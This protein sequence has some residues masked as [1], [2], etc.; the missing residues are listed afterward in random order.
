MIE[1]CWWKKGGGGCWDW[2]SRNIHNDTAAKE[3]SCRQDKR[4]VAPLFPALS[5]PLPQTSCRWGFTSLRKM[6][7]PGW[8][9]KGNLG[10]QPFSAFFPPKASPIHTSP[11]LSL[12]SIPTL[13]IALTSSLSPSA[14]FPFSLSLSLLSP[15]LPLF[16]LISLSPCLLSISPS[17]NPVWCV[18][19]RFILLS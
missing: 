17:Q 3:G 14:T 5:A 2:C 9:R 7:P 11:A 4:M 15:S 6:Y 1:G 13:S 12:P 16:P 10:L 18:A 19:S 8:Q